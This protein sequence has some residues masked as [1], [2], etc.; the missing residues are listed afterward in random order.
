MMQ[1]FVNMPNDKTVRTESQFSGILLSTQM[2][3]SD[4]SQIL[5]D[6]IKKII[7]YTQKFHIFTR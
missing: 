1:I 2:L 7:V 5:H 6:A 3:P 4:R